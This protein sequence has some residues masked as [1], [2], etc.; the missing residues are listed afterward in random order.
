MVVLFLH[1]IITEFPTKDI[2]FHQKYFLKKRLY[3]ALIEML[4]QLKVTMVSLEED[5]KGFIMYPQT[6]KVIKV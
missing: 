1:M 6:Y 3:F 2:L 4:S 5:M